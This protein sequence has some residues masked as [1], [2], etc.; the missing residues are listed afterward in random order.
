MK[1]V[2]IVED[3]HDTLKLLEGLVHNVD[4]EA[5]VFLADCVEKAYGDAL[6]ATIDLFIVDLMLDPKKKSGDMSGADFIR[7][8]FIKRIDLVNRYIYL[9]G[10]DDVLE[11]GSYMKKRFVKW[12]YGE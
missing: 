5:K 10:C 6:S 7:K 9:N 3:Q 2:L 11:I 1:K 8:K 4:A 12:F